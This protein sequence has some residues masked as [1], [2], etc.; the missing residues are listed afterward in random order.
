MVCDT[1]D[2]QLVWR[3]ERQVVEKKGKTIESRDRSSIDWGS[4]GRETKY[5]EIWMKKD[6]KREGES[7]KRQ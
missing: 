2:G 4:K 3:V 1:R 6:W 5:L 7:G